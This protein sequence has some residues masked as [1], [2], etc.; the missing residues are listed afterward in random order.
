MIKVRKLPTRDIREK[1]TIVRKRLWEV[2]MC[3]V[4]K[5]VILKVSKDYKAIYH[6][7]IVGSKFTKK[8]KLCTPNH[9]IDLPFLRLSIIAWRG[10]EATTEFKEK[11]SKDKFDLINNLLTYL[12]RL[13]NQGKRI[14]KMDLN[15]YRY[16]NLFIKQL[17]NSNK[18]KEIKRKIEKLTGNLSSTTTGP[19]LEDPVLSNFTIYKNKSCLVDLDNFSE[20]VNFFYEVGFLLADLKIDHQMIEIEL[21]NLWYLYQT[22][23]KIISQKSDETQLT[24]GYISRY[25]ILFLNIKNNPKNNYGYDNGE[26]LDY[27]Y[28]QLRS[29]PC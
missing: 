4:L 24:L 27:I 10:T 13:N 15:S 7:H 5:I 12:Y 21:K 26:A 8:S 3:S 6:K 23:N 11:K 17:D 19:G 28:N 2:N 29:I 16:L 9:F 22:G 18:A 14:A 20:T 25:A 1:L